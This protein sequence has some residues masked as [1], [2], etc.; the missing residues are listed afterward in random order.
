MF[1]VKRQ[2]WLGFVLGLSLLGLLAA[3]C[4]TA[5]GSRGW[6]P[7]V[8][9]D[10]LLMVSTDDG[11]LDGFDASDR[12][13]LWRF[14]QS[15]FIEESDARDLDGIYGPPVLSGDGRTI[16]IGD[17]NGFIYAFRTEGA[18]LAERPNAETTR[19]RLEAGGSGDRRVDLQR[20]QRHAACN[21]RAAPLLRLRGRPRAAHR[22]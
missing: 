10:N 8:Q 7:P 1:H 14:P 20:S 12:T 19:R 9:T 16:F 17:Y 21:L 18:N 6:A 4:S 15:W 13:L 22:R 11:R 3:G 5:A 2:R